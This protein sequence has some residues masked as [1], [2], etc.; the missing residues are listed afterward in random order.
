MAVR[1]QLSGL[2]EGL[3]VLECKASTQ[4]YCLSDQ[5]GFITA[6][7]VEHSTLPTS[8]VTP[9]LSRDLLDVP[10][11][12]TAWQTLTSTPVYVADGGT[13]TIGF[14][15]SKQGATDNAWLRFGNEEPTADKREGWWCATDF[16]LLYHP[17][18][19]RATEPQQWGT[20]CLPYDFPV[21]EGVKLYQVAGLTADYKKLCLEEVEQG[22]AGQ[23][24]IYRAGDGQETVFCTGGKAASTPRTVSNLRGY[25]RT[26]LFV[27]L[28]SYVLQDDG[29]WHR[30][31]SNRPYAASYSALL[32][33]ATGL[34]VHRTWSGATMPIQGVADE[35]GQPQLLPG[36]A[37]ADGMVNVSDV[38]AI[39]NHILGRTP[40]GF[41]AEAADA[42]GNGLVNVTDVTAV[43]SIILGK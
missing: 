30:I 4:H 22:L 36:D 21:P 35:L 24:Y 9:V 40:E 18:W 14:T 16:R 5:H 12:P 41:D 1:Q 20:V 25:F 6:A 26:T 39:I 42:D 31:T 34:T 38:T 10:S 27:P 19:R 15:G 8:A 33:R 29:Q 7:D 28:N 3:Y 2:A 13:L 17:L 23:P 43:I 11:T 37:N 32:T